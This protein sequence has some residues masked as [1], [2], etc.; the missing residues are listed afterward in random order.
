LG[1]GGTRDIAREGE[2]PITKGLKQRLLEKGSKK[3]GDWRYSYREKPITK[4]F[5]EKLLKKASKKAKG[6]QKYSQR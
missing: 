3:S 1:G 6:D 4:G 5:R 2:K